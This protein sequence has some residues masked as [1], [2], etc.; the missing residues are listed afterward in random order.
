MTRLSH[1][2][3]VGPVGHLTEVAGAVVEVIESCHTMW[4]FDHEKSAFCRVAKAGPAP[5]LT[6]EGLWHPFERLEVDEETGSFAV[7]L[8]PAGMRRLRSWQHV[9]P[10][11]LCGAGRDASTGELELTSPRRT[12]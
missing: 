10:C 8:D 2:H 12:S 7:V 4:H 11:R 9:D 1:D 3:A 6:D 5:D